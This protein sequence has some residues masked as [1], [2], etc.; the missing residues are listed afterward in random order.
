MPDYPQP[1]TCVLHEDRLKKIENT[2]EITSQD[3][4]QL[5]AYDGPIGNFDS[6]LV[7]VEASTERSHERITAIEEDTKAE[8]RR[9]NA[10]AVRVGS[11]AAILSSL[12][13]TVAGHFIK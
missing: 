13:A 4:K 7:V 6:R 11:I 8:S 10:L 12:L 9:L 5:L 3:V 2:V 1:A